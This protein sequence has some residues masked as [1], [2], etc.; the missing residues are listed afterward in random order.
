MEVKISY[1]CN[2]SS[3]AAPT[4]SALTLYNIGL[5][6]HIWA[7]TSG[8]GHDYTGIWSMNIYR[9]CAASEEGREV[10]SFNT[11]AGGEGPRLYVL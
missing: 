10:K 2:E 1:F 5:K 3:L 9:V 7:I 8:K 6:D 4:F 11:I